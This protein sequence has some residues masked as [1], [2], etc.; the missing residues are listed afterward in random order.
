MVAFDKGAQLENE[1]AAA[2]G[3]LQG[4]F[5]ELHA[6]PISIAKRMRE[7]GDN[8]SQT[9]ITRGV[10]RMLSGETRVSGE[11]LV[12]A[13]LLVRELRQSLKQYAA[14]EWKTL[15]NGSVTTIADQFNITLHPQTKGRWL[16][17]L[18]YLKTGYSPPWP[19]W[20]QSLDAAKQKAISCL[21]DVRREVEELERESAVA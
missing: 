20:Q 11:M 5:E 19:Q 21:E 12:I 1:Q 7:L 18:V 15:A 9:V 2:R 13:N 3:I 14:L 17:H 10:Y 8:R 16:V 6:T 4:A